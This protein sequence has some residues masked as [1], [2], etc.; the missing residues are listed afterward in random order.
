MQSTKKKLIK[1]VSQI[2][3][4]NLEDLLKLNGLEL[5]VF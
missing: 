4:A 2:V 1:Y 5:C 3:L